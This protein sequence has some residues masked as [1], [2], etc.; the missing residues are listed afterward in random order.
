MAPLSQ[1][2]PDEC[3]KYYHT[4][5]D[6]ACEVY[7]A[8]EAGW[9]CRCSS[10]HFA[11]LQLE[12]RTSAEASPLFNIFLSFLN[13]SSQSTTQSTTAQKTWVETQVNKDEFD[14]QIDTNVQHQ[15]S[16]KI[17]TDEHSGFIDTLRTSVITT[18]T[19]PPV[20]A[21]NANKTRKSVR[22]ME[23]NSDSEYPLKQQG[24]RAAALVTGSMC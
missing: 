1:P 3:S 14:E 11:N 24:K 21:S 9:R 5:R 18:G 23:P 8:L 16:D 19:F 20:M 6:N 2:R 10:P 15:G 7:H 4:V 22:I 17:R 13:Q 12:C